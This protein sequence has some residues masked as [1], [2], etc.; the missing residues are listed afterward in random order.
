[1]LS[2]L[3]LTAITDVTLGTLVDKFNDVQT[4]LQDMLSEGEEALPAINNV[5]HWGIGEVG[6]NDV[7]MAS[8]ADGERY[9]SLLVPLYPI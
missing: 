9:F 7:N 6:W 3:L 8:A 5:I 4:E 2:S 1:M